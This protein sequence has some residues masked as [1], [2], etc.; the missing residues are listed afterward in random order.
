[1]SESAPTDFPMFPYARFG[2]S[3]RVRMSSLKVIRNHE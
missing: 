3:N 2:S 1:M